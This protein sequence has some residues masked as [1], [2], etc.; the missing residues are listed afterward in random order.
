MLTTFIA[1]QLFDGHQFY[2]QRPITIENGKVV[3]FDRVQGAKQQRLSGLLVP[4]FID[5]QVNGGG[6]IL[7]NDFPNVETLA[8]MVKAHARFG[9]TAMLPTVITSDFSTQLQAADA[10]SNAIQQGIAGVIGIH[11]EGPHISI[12]KRGIHSQQHIRELTKQ[13]LELYCRD[14]LGIKMVTLAPEQV[15]E[16][17]IKLLTANHVIVCLGHSNATYQQTQH[18]LQAGARG[19]THLYNAMSAFTSREPNMV[20]AAL[21]DENSWC[22]LIL[23]G[24]HVHPASAK[25]ALKAKPQGKLMLVTDAMSTVGSEQRSFQFEQHQIEQHGNKLVSQTGQLA[26]SALTMIDAVNNAR[27]MLALN[28]EESLRMA[29]L[30]PAQFT[31]CHSRGQLVVGGAADFAL[32]QL[33]D[34]SYRVTSTW[35]G[36]QKVAVN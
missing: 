27:H 17:L 2:Q 34:D 19:F 8:T 29:S 12:P 7:F 25:L 5:V 36:G 11:F 24:H 15:D 14:D 16:Q 30:Y 35:I 1:D 13:E 32:L 23:D 21:E 26:G 6:G 33:I 31:R 10:V 3:S 20:G 22:G 9:T 4:G 18:A 28:A